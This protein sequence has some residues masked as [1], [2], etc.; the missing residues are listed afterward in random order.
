MKHTIL[1]INLQL[2]IYPEKK[3]I[4]YFPI[5]TIVSF[6]NCEKCRKM[7]KIHQ[8]N[9]LK[10]IYLENRYLYKRQKIS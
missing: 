1:D 6:I 10:K 8:N 3:T 4:G 9:M 5:V 2:L 7:S